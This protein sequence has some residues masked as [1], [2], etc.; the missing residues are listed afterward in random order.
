MP[1]WP[2]RRGRAHPDVLEQAM[3]DVL[4]RF[5]ED[6]KQAEAR[7]RG[8]GP[9]EVERTETPELD[10]RAIRAGTGLSQADFAR[11]VGVD[12]ATLRD[13]ELGRQRPEGNAR[14][15]LAM[16]AK[17]PQIAHR[18]IGGDS[19]DRAGGAELTGKTP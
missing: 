15:L 8:E 11:S 6:L 7:A 14:V 18:A 2:A 19:A 17:D 12:E 13:W 1:A 16:I 9:P 10:V 3:N 4:E 5:E